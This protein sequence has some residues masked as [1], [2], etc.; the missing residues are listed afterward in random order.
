MIEIKIVEQ[1]L[2]DSVWV[3]NGVTFVAIM[4]SAYVAYY[5]SK[6]KYSYEKLLDTKLVVL[7]E[8]YR[9]VIFLEREINK[10]ILVK[11]HG[12]SEEKRKEI[13]PVYDKFFELQNYFRENEIILDEDSAQN[14]QS[15]IDLSNEILANLSTSIVSQDLNAHQDSYDQWYKSYSLWKDKLPEAKKQLRVDFREAMTK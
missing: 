12:L 8:I 6:R 1:S 13:K 15:V 14:V 11:G 9:M 3:T 2:V 7:A 10:Y 4:L 5:F